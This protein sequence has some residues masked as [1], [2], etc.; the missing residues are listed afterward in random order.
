MKADLRKLAAAIAEDYAD[1]P[2]AADGSDDAAFWCAVHELAQRWT[3][4]LSRFEARILTLFGDVK[5]TKKQLAPRVLKDAA[6]RAQALSAA[7]AEDPDLTILD[8]LDALWEAGEHGLVAQWVWVLACLEGEASQYMLSSWLAKPEVERLIGSPPDCCP[9]CATGY[10]RT[11]RARSWTRCCAKRAGATSSLRWNTRC[12][13]LSAFSPRCR[14]ATASRPSPQN[15][16]ATAERTSRSCS[17]R[18]AWA[19]SK[20]SSRAARPPARQCRTRR[21]PIRSP[22]PS[23]RCIPCWRRRWP[24][25]LQTS[26]RRRPD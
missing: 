14:P 8:D 7:A 9:C 15:L 21:P 25:A 17:S 1:W 26:A 13:A 23:T 12:R 16:R 3:W 4:F 19:F 18:P 20:P 2:A 11:R 24:R 10:R 5:G 6:K 22:F